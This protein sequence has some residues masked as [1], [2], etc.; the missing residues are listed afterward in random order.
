MLMAN[1]A[2]RK[3]AKSSAGARLVPQLA[4]LGSHYP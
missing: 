3:F 1:Q 4:D 2:D